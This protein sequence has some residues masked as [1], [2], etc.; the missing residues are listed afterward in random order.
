[1]SSSFL[2][3]CSLRRQD[4]LEATTSATILGHADVSE[5]VFEQLS[6][7]E[8]LALAEAQPALLPNIKALEERW[9]QGCLDA[10]HGFANGWLKNVQDKGER[11]F[12]ARGWMDAFSM[13]MA[14]RDEFLGGKWAKPSW[15]GEDGPRTAPLWGA[16]M[17]QD[18]ERNSPRCAELPWLNGEKWTRT[19]PTSAERA[20]HGGHT[21]RGSHGR[22]GLGSPRGLKS[23]RAGR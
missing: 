10:T 2:E 15:M 9:L 12:A 11:I 23:R 8:L 7:A 14:C 20:R 18:A 16:S 21:L 13:L 22:K 5:I 1:M 3:A 19:Q 4:S 6:L 17:A